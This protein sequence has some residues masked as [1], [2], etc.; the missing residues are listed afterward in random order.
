MSR[1]NP[2]HEFPNVRVRLRRVQ[3]SPG[4]PVREG[5]LQIWL[6]GTRFR[7][8]DEAGRRLSTIL[9]DLPAA[10]GLGEAP[11]TL[12]EMMDI[13]SASRIPADGVTDLYGDLATE[14]GWV[15]RPGQPARPAEA[16]KLAPVAAQILA[17]ELTGLEPRGHA[18]RL[19]RDC[20]EYQGALAGGSAVTYIVSPPYL[21][22]SYVH[23]A[24]DAGPSYTREII[25]LDEGAVTEED[26]APPAGPD[27]Q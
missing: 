20:T 18:T 6:Q 23:K 22:F 8:R 4:L 3:R 26:L 24:D 27:L 16:G 2:P 11:R 7:V 21:L 5:I 19:G 1:D 17:G 9:A 13:Q 14:E 25:S 15:F 12:E 10:S